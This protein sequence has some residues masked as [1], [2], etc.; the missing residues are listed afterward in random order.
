M[1]RKVQDCQEIHASSACI[2]VDLAT[3]WKRYVCFPEKQNTEEKKKKGFLKIR[4][5][6]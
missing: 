6:F 1:N 5:S 4:F 3:S 2:F